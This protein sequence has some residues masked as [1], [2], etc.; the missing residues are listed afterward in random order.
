MPPEGDT[1][2]GIF[3]PGGT[4]I[5]W[6]LFPLMLSEE[7][8]GSDAA[9]FRPERFMDADAKTRAQMERLV[10]LAFGSGRFMCAGKPLAFMELNKVFFEVSDCV[11][12]GHAPS[13]L[14]SW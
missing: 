5:S 13:M 4:A 8:W 14:G 3:V 6:N 9:M 7:H 12:F 10:E 11:L 1:I 2:N